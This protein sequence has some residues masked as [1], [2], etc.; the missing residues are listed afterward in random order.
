MELPQDVT[1]DVRRRLRRI[2]GQ[3]QGVER[4]LAEGRD[5]QDV[6]TQM[7]AAMRALEQAGVRLLAAGLVYCIEH[8]DEAKS[9]GYA[10]D[11]I[12]KLFTK[13]T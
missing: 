2:A 8:P 11:T 9:T 4:M 1:D 13:L 3:V 12:E 7:S 10:V 6:V 5:C